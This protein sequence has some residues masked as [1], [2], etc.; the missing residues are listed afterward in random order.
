MSINRTLTVNLEATLAEIDS[1]R[2]LLGYSIGITPGNNFSES[3]YDIP[4]SLTTPN[5]VTITSIVAAFILVS[6]APVTVLVTDVF[7]VVSTFNITSILMF[8]SAAT[9]VV[10]QNPIT[11]TTDAL[12][13]V[14]SC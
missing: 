9:Q 6:N 1:F 11:N 2:S 13:T 12:I 4:A 10:V 7:G 5:F 8:T 14:I 3:R